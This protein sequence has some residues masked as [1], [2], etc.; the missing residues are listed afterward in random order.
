M[1]RQDI[2]AFSV[3]EADRLLDAAVEEL[4]YLARQQD[5]PGI[6]VIRT[7]PGRFTVELGQNVPYGFTLEALV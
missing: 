7:G 1:A 3:E 6:L 2:S 5:G 4:Q